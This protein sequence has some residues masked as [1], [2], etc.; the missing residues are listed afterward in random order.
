MDVY[1][2]VPADV[3]DETVPSGGNTYDRE[4]TKG[5]AELGWIVQPVPVSGP[6]ALADAL[7]AVPDGA[8]VLA[9][10]LVVC[11]APD[12]VVPASQRLRVTVLVHMPRANEHGLP[13][14]IAADLDSRERAVLGAAAAVIATS[15]WSAR[16]IE[17]HHGVPHV[18]VA[19][20]GTHRADIATGTDGVSRLLCVAAVTPGKGLD[21]LVEALARVTD[22]PWTCDVVGSLHRDPGFVEHVR[23]LIGRHCLSDRIRLT[24]PHA[25][26]SDDYAR[27]D[28]FVLASRSETFGMVVAES[29]ARGIPVLAT[30]VGAIPDTL[31]HAPGGGTPGLLVPPDVAAFAGT[32]RRWLTEPALRASLRVAAVARRESIPDWTSTAHAISDVLTRQ[33]VAA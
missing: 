12:V 5:L 20:P 18:D 29:L 1:F 26:L 9:D 16:Q 30:D 28:L 8:L 17:Q 15:P 32:L 31:G 24:G 19:I 25:D 13:A 3:D 10:G 27:T 11:G 4:I 33:R 6:G 14:P 7:A 21:L 23:H 22:L 2:V